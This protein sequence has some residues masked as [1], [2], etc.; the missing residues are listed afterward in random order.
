M[1]QSGY[2]FSVHL[3]VFE[4]SSYIQTAARGRSAQS[5]DPLQISCDITARKTYCYVINENHD[6][7]DL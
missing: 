5:T 4:P 7:G 2:Q 6:V 3:S 1:R